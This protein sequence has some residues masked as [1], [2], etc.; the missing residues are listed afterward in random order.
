VLLS[1]TSFCFGYT[2]SFNHCPPDSNV[3]DI[4]SSIYIPIKF[5]STDMTTSHLT[6]P[7]KYILQGAN[8]EKG[9]VTLTNRAKG[10]GY[11]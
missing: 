10:L 6:F 4:N 1:N 3:F 7:V 11:Q 5:Q 8:L 2:L 9:R